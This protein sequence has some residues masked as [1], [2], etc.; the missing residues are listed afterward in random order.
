LIYHRQVSPIVQLVTRIQDDDLRVADPEL[1]S[2]M[3]ALDITP[4]VYGMYVGGA[5]PC[6]CGV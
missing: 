2:H 5:G 4:Q 1:H 3:K 6:L